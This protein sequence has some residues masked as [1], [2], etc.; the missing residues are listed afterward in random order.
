MIWCIKGYQTVLS[1]C[2]PRACRFWPSCSEYTIGAV[3]AYGLA[4]GMLLGMWRILRCNPWNAGGVDPVPERLPAWFARA[5]LAGRLERA[6]G[7]CRP[8][9]SGANLQTADRRRG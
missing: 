3:R 7:A 9:G 1:P 2:L 5:G 6:D 8:Q 4:A